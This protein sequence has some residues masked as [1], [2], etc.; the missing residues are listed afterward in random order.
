MPSTR[1]WL[2]RTLTSTSRRTLEAVSVRPVKPSAPTPRASA[3][4]R[5]ARPALGAQPKCVLAAAVVVVEH[6]IHHLR[7]A[8]GALARGRT[9]P[10]ARELVHDALHERQ[11]HVRGLFDIDALQLIAQTQL[12]RL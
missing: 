10:A 12:Q 8:P 6:A 11:V 7:R 2:A 9:A 4:G 1:L 5:S 3:R